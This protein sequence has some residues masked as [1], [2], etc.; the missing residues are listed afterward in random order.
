MTAATV[1]TS[2]PMALKQDDT[3]AH[4]VQVLLREHLSSLPV[5]DG[6]GRYLGTFG[7]HVVLGLLLPKA[8][9]WTEGVPDLAFLPDNL[10][11][12]RRHLGALQDEP[13]GNHLDRAAPLVRPNAPLVEALLLLY[14]H[15]GILPVVEEQDGKLVGSVS[16]CDMLR[17]LTAPQAE[18]R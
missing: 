14:R 9:T 16:A 13:V 11:Y 8:A 7:M 5:I 15:D 17:A 4:A 12:L 3:L 10:E 6:Q 1:M 2:P 18:G